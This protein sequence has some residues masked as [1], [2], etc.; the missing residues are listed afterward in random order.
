MKKITCFLLPYLIKN[1]ID[2]TKNKNNPS[3]LTYENNAA[4]P[5]DAIVALFVFLINKNNVVI[6][7]NMNKGSV[8]PENEFCTILG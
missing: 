1:I 8:I 6:P 4:T 5:K 3:Y 7:N 2:N